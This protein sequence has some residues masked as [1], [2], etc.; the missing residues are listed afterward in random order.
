MKTKTNFLLLYII[1]F[2]IGCQKNKEPGMA[3]NLDFEVVEKGIP[4]GW[5]VYKQ[6][7]NSSISLDTKCVKS[8]KYSVAI[9][10][11]NNSNVYQSI[12]LAIPNIYDGEIVTLTGYIKTVNVEGAA[13][14]AVVT[15]PGMKV[16]TIVVNGTTDWAKYEVSLQ[17]NPSKDQ[18]IIISGLLR[19]KGKVWFDDFSVTIDG[20]DI[21]D[22]KIYEP[23][24]FPAESDR[25]FLN[26][27]IS[28][29]LSSKN[30]DSK[31]SKTIITNLELLGKIWGFL[32]Y[33]HPEV[34]RGNYNW[35]NELFRILP[36]YVK[37]TETTQRDEILLQW[38]EKYGEVP[39]CTTCAETSPDAILKPDLSWIGHYQM[40]TRLTEKLSKVYQNRSQEDHYYLKK[41]PAGNPVFVNE[42]S[43]PLMSGTDVGLRLL[44]LYRYWNMIQYFFPYK[45]LTDKKWEG[46]LKAY[47]PKFVLA[48]TE[49]KY[50]LAVLQLTGE[51]ND[52]H[53]NLKGV[54]DKVDSLRGSWYVPFQVKFIEDKLVVVDYYKP[55]LKEEAGLNIGDIITHINNKTIKYIV[56]SV[57]VYYPASN[58]VSRMKNIADDLLRSP[59]ST[60]TIDYISA[61]QVRRKTELKL[62]DKKSAQ[63]QKSGNEASYKYL[64]R[65]NILVVNDLIGYI[66]LK[67]IAGAEV[68][69]IKK[70]F[71]HTIGIVIDI[72]NYPHTFVPFTLGTFF[73][74]EER[75]FARFSKVNMN[76]PGEF[77]LYPTVNIPKSDKP[78]KGKLVVI[79]N[80]ETLS[81][82]EYTAMAFRAGD[83]T[84]IIGS[85]TSGADGNVSEIVL[86][87][88]IK[89][90]FSGIGVYYPDGRETQRIGIVPDIIVK[91]TIQGIREGRDV[92]LEKAIEI[93]LKN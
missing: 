61:D 12:S 76:N 29:P 15:T 64:N 84:T 79:V 27:N 20:V 25:A 85:Q 11:T 47:I 83:N 19:G 36:S 71:V 60:I 21:K 87:G 93:I 41:E 40:D 90:S 53:A 33:H 50:Q 34:A 26:S 48:D 92:L 5:D 30:I 67:T 78:Y 1:L 18:Q 73:M 69:K 54:G 35:D 66:T 88:S 52:S 65:D 2:S 24:P 82:A 72:R 16:D 46:V 70:E 39:I 32:K 63:G 23:K 74:S 22:A 77:S 57:K 3:L 58:E 86:P 13:G 44:A 6:P 81:Q 89:T 75:P 8:G 80:E 4:K 14:L 62:Y 56:D 37:A 28:I 59:N 9:E 49:L 17:L 45:H 55:E 68:D 31:E 7:D 10:Y 91:P 43:Y 51:I 42:N 38:I